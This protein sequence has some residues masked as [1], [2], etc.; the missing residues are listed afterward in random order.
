MNKMINLRNGQV[1]NSILRINGGNVLNRKKNLKKRKT[2]TKNSMYK[3]GDIGKR[4]IDP[5]F[6]NRGSTHW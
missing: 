2:V 5:A 6:R 4:D 3:T 1:R